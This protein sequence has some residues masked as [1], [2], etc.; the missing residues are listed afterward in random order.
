MTTRDPCPRC[1]K[2]H[3][4]CTGHNRAGGPCGA[5]PMRHQAV[6]KNHGGKSPRALAAAEN[7]RQHAE[8]EQQLRSVLA[9][10]YGDNV[11][12]V[13][14]AEAM[15]RAVSWK[16]AEVVA[17]RRKVAELDDDARIWGTTKVKDGGVDRGTTSEAKPHIWWQML[18]TAEDALVKY[19]AAARA[20]GCDERRV[21]IAE[22][23]GAQLAAI[24]RSILDAFHD[25]LVAAGVAVTQAL[26]QRL[27]SEIVPRELRAIEGGA[28]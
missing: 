12:D 15:L 24:I 23:L 11:P 18:R 27:M 4:G 26:W 10:A 7:R 20:A 16:Y 6:C 19:A 13:D 17:L 3:P 8:A 9:E 28:A 22:D 2:A 14:P 1:N 25:G 5:P 21:R